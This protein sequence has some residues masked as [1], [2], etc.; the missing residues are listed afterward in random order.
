[1]TSFL[2]TCMH[3]PMMQGQPMQMMGQPMM[4]QQAMM[5]TQNAPGVSN[6]FGVSTPPITVTPTDTSQQPPVQAN[7]PQVTKKLQA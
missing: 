6:G 1:M 3:Q 7:G 4:N 5:M 2:L